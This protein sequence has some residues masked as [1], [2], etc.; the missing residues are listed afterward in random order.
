MPARLNPK[1]AMLAKVA[2]KI[3]P[4]FK[5]LDIRKLDK[6]IPDIF[7]GISTTTTHS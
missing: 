1:D 2:F 6:L 5:I 4:H 7:V 3:K